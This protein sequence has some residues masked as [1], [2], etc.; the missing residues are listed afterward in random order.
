MPLGEGPLARPTS[1]F[2]DLPRRHGVT[3]LAPTIAVELQYKQ[4]TAGR[5]R[6]P[7]LRGFAKQASAAF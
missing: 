2:A 6:A 1:P 5:L 3:W 4:M 7:V